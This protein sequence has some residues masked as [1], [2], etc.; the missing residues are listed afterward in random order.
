MLS[1]SGAA[2]ASTS[3]VPA[4]DES[5]AADVGL[6]RFLAAYDETVAP[7]HRYLYRASGGDRA[8]VDDV[9]QE[10][11]MAAL[12]HA[13]GGDDSVL[14]LPWLMRVARNKLVDHFRR[15]ERE[16]RRTLS[17]AMEP[18]PLD[19]ELL[20]AVRAL[21]PIQRAAVALRYVDDLSVGEVARELGKSLK[22][23]ESLL[24]RGRAALRDSLSKDPNE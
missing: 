4:T 15:A 2:T 1:D 7:I 18:P 3:S 21:P 14:T 20:A 13:R 16:T 10:T 12:V 9:A 11:Y 24:S 23:T 8:L 6:E 5:V 22:A 17:P 19:D